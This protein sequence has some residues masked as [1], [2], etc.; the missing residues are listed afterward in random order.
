[1]LVTLFGI[2]IDVSPMKLSNAP[3]LMLVPPV[4][5][6]VL[7]YLGRR[8]LPRNGNVI[9]YNP[10]QPSNADSAI[11]KTLSGIVIEVSP[12]QPENAEPPML[13]PPVITT[14]LKLAGTAV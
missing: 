6:T 12:L 7:K 11:F 9:E 3:A 2:V 8:V 13:V 4:I 5:T 10:L 1:M 14:V